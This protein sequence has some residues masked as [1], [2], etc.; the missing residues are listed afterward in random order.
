MAYNKVVS[1]EQA[2]EE[3]DN[4]LEDR[5]IQPSI[6]EKNHDSIE[7]IVEAVVYGQ[8]AL[9][10]GQFVQKLQYP[11]KKEKTDEVILEELT[12]KNR[13]TDADLSG[14]LRNLDTS[15]PLAFIKAYLAALTDK[16][17]PLLSKLESVD[18]RVAN[19]IVVFFAT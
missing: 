12:Y 7:I 9:V 15:N 10:D 8:L 1:F 16:P 18:K 6:I 5:R 3:V 2:R 19:A 17:K 11:L 4:W 13:L 14:H